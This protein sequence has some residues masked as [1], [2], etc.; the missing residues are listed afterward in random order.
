MENPLQQLEQIWYPGFSWENFLKGAVST[1][2]S[3]GVNVIK[4][5]AQ[6]SL[7][8]LGEFQCCD[9]KG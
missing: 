4:G 5:G 8:N 9:L 1:G 3:A 7:A 6:I 2:C